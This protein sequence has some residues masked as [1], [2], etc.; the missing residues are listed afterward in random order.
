M[1][2]VGSLIGNGVYPVASA[3]TVAGPILPSAVR[4]GTTSLLPSGEKSPQ[5][6]GAITRSLLPSGFAVKTTPDPVVGSVVRSYV[7]CPLVPRG[8]APA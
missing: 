8:L 6:P 3:L 5:Q 1:F 7:I 2:S 4:Y